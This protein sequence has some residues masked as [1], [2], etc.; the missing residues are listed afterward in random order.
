MI[1]FERRKKVKNGVFLISLAVVLAVSLGLIGCGGEGVPKYYLTTSSTEGGSV[2]KPGEGTFTYDEGDVVNLEADADEGYQFISWTG[3]VDDV[4]DV[5]GAT[6]TITMNGS[7]EIKAAFE[8]EQAPKT[9][10][11]MI[12]EDIYDQIQEDLGVFKSDLTNEGYVVEE[13]LV[14][15]AA[16]PLEIRSTIK[17]YYD[18]DNL[19]GAILVGDIVA[20]YFEAH[21]GDF[22]NP[23][24]LEIWIALDATDMYYMDLDGDWEH[25]ANPRFCEDAPPNVVECNEYPSCE[26]FRNEYLVYLDED[27]EWDYS[28]IEDKEQYKAE[29]W[30]SRI[31]GH[32]L[33][34]PDTSATPPDLTVSE[35]EI[36]G[37]SV[38]VNGVVH[39]GTGGTTITR[40]RWDWGDGNSED[41]WFAASHTYAQEGDYVIAVTAYQSDGLYRIET[42]HISLLQ[43]STS[44]LP[45]LTVFEP[46]IDGLSVNVNGVV[47]PGTDG[48]SIT[49][50]HWDWGDGNSEDHWF[51]ASHTYAQEGD[52][53]IAVTAYQS[54]GLYSIETRQISWRPSRSEAQI[55]ND[56]FRWNH[57]Y[58]TG[59]YAVSDKA[60][61]LCSG[62]G[63]N[64]QEMDYSQI[65]STVVKAE[66]VTEGEF[67]NY[68]Q[69]PD[70]SELMYFTAHSGPQV[71]V[72]YDGGMS[73]SELLQLQKNSVFYLLNACSSCRWDQYV[74]SPLSPNYLGG[75]YVFSKTHSDGDYG[76]GAIGFTGVGGFNNLEFFTDYLNSVEEPTYG[77]AFVF[78]FNQNLMINFGIHNYVFLGDPTIGPHHGTDEQ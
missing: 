48:T 13:T 36:D 21:T 34:I 35:P 65:F 26:T 49:R 74:S 44:A 61:L 8:E 9:V 76:L 42:R 52:Y 32:N 4:A 7:Y 72:W 25:V 60:Y 53:V 51:A 16:E 19:V 18:N 64:D 57:E 45:D 54:D 73:A 70:G 39:P 59:D 71:H 27:K 3:D 6:T 30:V 67:M 23:D 22:S 68:L 47:Y 46:E 38:N 56:F 33:D 12:N 69:D 2:A 75:L 50:I 62:D 20:P 37:L 31:M 63:Y 66:K 24:A 28:E 58:R 11:I 10:L 77:D 29:I 41:H 55:I 43:Q 17:S 78:W 5:E 1:G 15:N 40:I 14:D